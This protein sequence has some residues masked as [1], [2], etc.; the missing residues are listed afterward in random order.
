MA[1]LQAG[2]IAV[3]GT[4]QSLQQVAQQSGRHL[5]EVLSLAMP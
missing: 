4:R 5:P 3:A 2:G 1:R